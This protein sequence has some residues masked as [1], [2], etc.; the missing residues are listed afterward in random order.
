[1]RLCLSRSSLTL[2]HWGVE[3]VEIEYAS[4]SWVV[5]GFGRLRVRLLS[6]RIWSVLDSEYVG[7]QSG[8]CAQ[9][10]K[11]RCDLHRRLRLRLRQ[12]DL[13]YLFQ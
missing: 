1:M 8:L 7:T 13:R 9:G 5:F 10:R 4:Q 12:L 3:N 2:R 6:R 11:Q